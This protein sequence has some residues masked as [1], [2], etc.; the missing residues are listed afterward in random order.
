MAPPSHLPYKG[1]PL[2]TSPHA[3]PPHQPHAVTLHQGYPTFPP[4]TLSPPG[5][6]LPP[7]LPQ[8]NP[9]HQLHTITPQQGYLPLPNMFAPQLGYLILPLPQGFCQGFC[10][11]FSGM[12]YLLMLPYLPMAGFGQQYQGQGWP[13]YTPLPAS[14]PITMPP[15]S[16]QQWGSGNIESATTK[17]KY[18]NTEIWPGGKSHSNTVRKT[19]YTFYVSL[20]V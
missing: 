13:I 7:T 11:G 14:T 3:D 16:G 8:A 5:H 20:V 10:Q 6:H 12:Q 2:S 15:K 1:H 19:T 9:S 4:H 17:K 18:L